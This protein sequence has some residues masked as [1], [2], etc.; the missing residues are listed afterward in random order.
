MG[1]SGSTF[2]NKEVNNEKNEL[3][4]KRAIEDW[5]VAFY[6]ELAQVL[7][8]S[9]LLAYMTRKY[10]NILQGKFL[11]ILLCYYLLMII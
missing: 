2:I 5:Q 6:L 4:M 11:K 3:I 8:Y 10:R 9:I 1:N 7:L